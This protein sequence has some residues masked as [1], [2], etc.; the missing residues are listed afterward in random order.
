MVRLRTAK[1]WILPPLLYQSNRTFLYYI[2]HTA[3]QNHDICTSQIYVAFFL[4]NILFLDD[5]MIDASDDITFF[6][7]G[8]HIFCYC[9]TK[10]KYLILGKARC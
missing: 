3:K 2:F 9:P 7:D 6:S 5:D 8:Y 4:V 10:E 1:K